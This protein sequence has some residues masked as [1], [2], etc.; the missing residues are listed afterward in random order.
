[1]V[2]KPAPLHKQAPEHP[3]LHRYQKVQASRLGFS[4]PASLLYWLLEAHIWQAGMRTSIA[5]RLD[6]P[7]TVAAAVAPRSPCLS[8]AWVDPRTS[9][10]LRALE[11]SSLPALLPHSSKNCSICYSVSG[12]CSHTCKWKLD[13]M[14]CYSAGARRLPFLQNMEAQYSSLSSPAGVPWLSSQRKTI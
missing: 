10:A 8:I 11:D 13:S 9:V 4:V 14:I 12:A 3:L 6:S 7:M 5:R 1:M 2:E